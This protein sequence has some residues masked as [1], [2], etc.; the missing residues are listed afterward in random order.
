ML[1]HSLN[2]DV[3]CEGWVLKKRR[4]K[5]QGF[6]RR[7]FTLHQS[8]ILSYSFEPGQPVRDQVSLQHA[9]IS[10]A[11]G[12]KDIHVDSNTATFHLKCL[13]TDDFNTWM[14]AFRK[15]ISLG[16]EARRSASVRLASRHGN[17][18]MSLSKSGTIAEE[19]GLTIASLEDSIHLLAHDL[20]AQTKKN[21]SLGKKS[22]KD[23]SKD[24]NK[25]SRFG[26]FK[27]S[28][29][30][31]STQEFG[32][33][34][35]SDAA[36]DSLP[37]SFRRVMSAMETLK[38]Q[39]A[40][41]LTSMQDLA[42]LRQSSG[43]PLPATAEE[44]D[45][46]HPPL[47]STPLSRRSK[48]ASTTTSVSDSVHEWFDALDGP[49]EFVVDVDGPELPSRL[50]TNESRS[51]LGQQAETS[52]I[53]TDIGED[54]KVPD[55]QPITPTSAQLTREALQIKRRTLLPAMP[56][57][58]EG[59]LFAI[60]KKNVGKDL[61]TITFPVT[62]NEP[63]T[64]LQRAA[65]EVEYYSVL[66]EA[67]KADNPVDKI[68]YVAAFA[69]SSYA[70]TRHRSGRKGFNPMLGET[71][72]DPRMKFI[73]EKVR[74]NPLE[75]AYHAEGE[76]WELNAT[77]SGKTKFWGKSLEIIPLGNTHVKIG[78]DHYVWKKPSSFMRNLM[79]GTKYLEHCGNMIIE[80]TR[81][82]T[83]CV[84]EFKQA[85]YWGPSNVVSG[86]VHRGSSG[87]VL[88]HLEGKWD[89]QMA[90]T[91]DSSNFRVLWRMTP[92]PKNTHD[93]YGFTSFGITLNEMTS[94]LVGKL[95]PTDSRFRPDVKALENGDLDVAEDQK[96]RVEELQ[97][98]RRR[99]GKD[100]QP[101][102]FHQEGEDWIY[103]GGY[104]EARQR[105]WKDE[106]ILPLWQTTSTQTARRRETKVVTTSA[107][108]V[109]HVPADRL[110][111]NW[112]GTVS[113]AVPDTTLAML[114]VN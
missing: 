70:H 42:D 18:S 88:M 75:M 39:H 44:E 95:P 46:D 30:H 61:S 108:H 52:S 69:V 23:K 64:L 85:G 87:D 34:T 86:T 14:V 91:F 74:H 31:S 99:Q 79:V 104:W 67:A 65:E 94:D 48:R 58:D 43:S 101:R 59:S 4:K 26:L 72:E 62:F 106:E 32:L 27:K 66:D 33:G 80:N 96:I 111:L 20:P 109:V 56:V 47:L 110:L 15:F 6:A 45:P 3:V 7:Y 36:G 38:A 83:R 114:R 9:A 100:R 22:D 51:S 57:G 81:D 24:S 63:L 13:S 113:R 2:A 8:G 60:L 103:S 1:S 17:P 41:L 11:R 68:C 19:M 89:D 5:M 29:H 35:A 37:P 84:L 97:R 50:L 92:F 16:M 77:S 93:Y 73:A 105:G 25:D 54:V 71:F 10:T 53:D 28:A 76:N 90:Q 40:S 102:W 12:R 55:Q 21:H 112:W 98:E 78:Q 107:D 82:R 49:E